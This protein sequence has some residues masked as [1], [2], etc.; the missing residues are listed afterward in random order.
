MRLRDALRVSPGQALA[1]VGAGGKSSAMQCLARE[2]AG[3]LPVVLT[4]TTRLGIEQS[5]LVQAH[6]ATGSGEGI[7]HLRALLD[8]RIPVLITGPLEAQQKKWMGIGGVVMDELREAVAGAAGVLLVEADGAR[9]RSL[10]APAAHEPII[11]SFVNAVVPMAGLDAVGARL[12]SALVH[13]PERVAALLGHD[14]NARLEA[15]DVARLF[16]H[17]EGG[18]KGVPPGCEVR[19]LLNKADDERLTRLGVQVAEGAMRSSALRSA[20]VASLL[21]EDPVRQVVG[22]V[23]GVVLAA[24]GSRRLKSAKQT[25]PW[26]GRPLVWYAV[27]AALDGGLDPVVVVVGAQAEVVAG[28]VEAEAVRI[29]RNPAWE[30]G[31]SASLR[32]GLAEVGGAAEA[33]VFLLAD[34]PRVDGRLVSALVEAHRRSLAPIVAPR[35]GGRWANPVLFDRAVFPALAAVE[36]DRGGRALFGRYPI[37]GVDWTEDVL[38]DVDTP[39]DVARL[40]GLEGGP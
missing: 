31:Q 21:D 29:V 33:V 28:A 26:R 12:D 3:E 30:A 7:P 36:G 39:E 19:A 32:L 20:V 40:R 9:G 4:C 16:R 1:F 23:A 24:G 6:F 22:R 5:G 25:I 34:T 10:K 18:M 2:L 38:L 37:L 13:R 14:Q 27:R 15:E 11:P 8:A 35:A 17:P